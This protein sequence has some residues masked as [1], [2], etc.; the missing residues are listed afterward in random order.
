MLELI[1]LIGWLRTGAPFEGPCCNRNR[2]YAGILPIEH[3]TV[4]M[5][6]D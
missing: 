5:H 3:Q 4:Q 1:R 2:N 6:G